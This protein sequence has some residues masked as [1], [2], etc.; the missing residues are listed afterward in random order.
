[1]NQERILIARERTLPTHPYDV[2]TS[3]IQEKCP[4]FAHRFHLASLPFL[5]PESSP[6]RLLVNW[7]QDPLDVV[8]PFTFLQALELEQAC[9]SQ[10]I[11][12]VNAMSNHQNTGKIRAYSRLSKAGI[13][14]PR[15]FHFKSPQEFMRALPTLPYPLILRDDIGHAGSFVLCQNEDQLREAPF[16]T[17]HRPILS[18]YVDVQSADRRYRK[19]R[20]IVVGNRVI[21]HHLQTSETWETRGNQRIKDA[22]T[23]EE[24]IAYILNPDP[25]EEIMLKVSQALELEFLG[26]DYGIDSDGDVVIWEAN[27][28]PHLHFSKVDLV[29]RNFAMDRTIAAMVQY[30]LERAGVEPPQKLKALSSYESKV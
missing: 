23:R 9:R 25:F 10:Q 26:I 20:C 18:E 7:F 30:Y 4:D 29:Y 16:H 13:Y 3:W 22:Q 1:M 14:T 28:F 12:V 19:Y 17:F 11:P 21:S 24:E 8:N 5:P 15:I 27:Q 6:Y 2:V